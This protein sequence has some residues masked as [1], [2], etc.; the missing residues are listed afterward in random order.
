MPEKIA[1]NMDQFDGVG[2][3]TLHIASEDVPGR[4]VGT[5]RSV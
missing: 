5:H 2:S 3:I 4:P 1:L